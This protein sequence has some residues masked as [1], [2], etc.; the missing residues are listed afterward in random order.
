[1]YVKKVYMWN[2]SVYAYIAYPRECNKKG[3]L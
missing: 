2:P 1:M 3:F